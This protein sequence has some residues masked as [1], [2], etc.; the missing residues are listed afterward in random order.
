MC[1][2][3]ENS[4]KCRPT[5]QQQYYRY[6]IFTFKK[7]KNILNIKLNNFF[8]T[9]QIDCGIWKN[10]E[11]LVSWTSEYFF[12]SWNR[13]YRNKNKMTIN[14]VCLLHFIILNSIFKIEDFN[15]AK[16]VV[17]IAFFLNDL[18]WTDNLFMLKVKGQSLI[19]LHFA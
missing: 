5:S 10:F 11:K 7:F 19:D 13:S 8:S 18:W 2:K 15:H 17:L 3:I 9:F 12:S 16:L 14:K 4:K 1:A 6:Q